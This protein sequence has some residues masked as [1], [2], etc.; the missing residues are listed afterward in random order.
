MS[1][2]IK[3]DKN[4]HR[5]CDCNTTAYFCQTYANALRFKPFER[6]F[7]PLF[8]KKTLPLYLICRLKTI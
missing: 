3:L 7:I 5:H 1:E 8:S 6:V 4:T 2:R